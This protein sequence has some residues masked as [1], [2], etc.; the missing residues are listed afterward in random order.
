MFVLQV[1]LGDG[2]V[3]LVAARNHRV[4]HVQE[5]HL[6]LRLRSVCL[7]RFAMLNWSAVTVVSTLAVRNSVRRLTAGHLGVGESALAF[8]LR[9]RW[10]RSVPTYGMLDKL[11]D[12]HRL[13][14]ALLALA[15]EVGVQHRQ[16]TPS[17]RHEERGARQTEGNRSEVSPQVPPERAVG[18]GADGGLGVWPQVSE[19]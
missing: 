4:D 13:A 16:G 10:A 19:R 6:H 18:F 14:A 17:C 5:L 1:R 7:T 8:F 3:V 9:Q 2:D 11:R 12:G 15:A